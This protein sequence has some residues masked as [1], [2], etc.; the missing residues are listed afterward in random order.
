MQIIGEQARMVGM[1]DSIPV[2]DPNV[3]QA[4]EEPGRFTIVGSGVVGLLVA[5]ELAQQGHAVQVVSAEGK[6]SMSTD[7]T[8]SNAIGQFLPWMPEGHA[9]GVMGD[10]PLG[11]VV[12]GSR[13]FWAELAEDPHETG[14]MAVENVELLTDGSP[15]PTDLPEA[16]HVS[17]KMLDQPVTFIDPDGK[18]VPFDKEY[19]FGT[20]SISARKAMAYLAKRAEELGVRFEQRSLSP[21]DLEQL[22]GIVINAA[23]L[24]A[25]DFD[26]GQEV[27]FFKGHTFLIQPG[28]DSPA[29]VQ[30]L[31]VEDLIIMPR[32]DGTVICGAL[33]RENP[34]RPVPEAD[35]A[36][37]LKARLGALVKEMA[38]LVEGLDPDLFDTGEVLVHSAGYRVELANGGIRVAP[39]EK[40][41]KLLHAY[42]FA[43]VGWSVG[44]HFAR[45][46]ASM[47]RE[48]HAKINNQEEES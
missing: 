44:P 14:V 33:Y 29:L 41:E 20:F 3:L 37:E 46:I 36:E 15:W 24:G 43:G 19:T 2:P 5:N 8:S 13:S 9:G 31:S 32:E 39:D 12:E 11:E 47:A 23:G 27:K 18:E 45:E 38:P 10:L 4:N 17:E 42:G 28:A 16:M 7:S 35:E 6:P 1:A 26:E 40:N 34:E 25:R 21:Q 48:M 22:E 30:A